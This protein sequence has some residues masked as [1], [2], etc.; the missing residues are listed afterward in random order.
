MRRESFLVQAVARTFCTGVYQGRVQKRNSEKW[1]IC[2]LLL[3]HRRGRSDI[4]VSGVETWMHLQ[5]FTIS[6]K[7]E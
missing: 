1:V 6:E 4:M 3:F 5:E 7:D 2:F